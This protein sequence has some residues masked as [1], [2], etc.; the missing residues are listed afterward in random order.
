MAKQYFSSCNDIIVYKVSKVLNVFENAKEI[1]FK[2]HYVI[3]NLNVY[4]V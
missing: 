1:A 4:L 3:F 2:T